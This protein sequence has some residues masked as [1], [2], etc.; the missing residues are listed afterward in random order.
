MS[1]NI[2]RAR[3]LAWYE[4]NYGG[5]P[6]AEGRAKFMK[7]TA[8]VGGKPI[9]KGRVTQLFDQKEAFGEMAARNLGERLGLGAEWFL[10]DRPDFDAPKSL[11]ETAAMTPPP[12]PYGFR[13][14][15][16]VSDS[17]FSLLQD[18]KTAMESPR[19]A[20]Q[21][22][23]LRKEAAAMAAFASKFYKDR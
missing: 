8:K 11:V 1:T 18:I 9:S 4:A 3:F 23:E 21:V 10:V 22:E 14:R 17:D 15:H 2:R 7:A 16:E 13:D 19:G 5:L 20:A 6:Q 12:P